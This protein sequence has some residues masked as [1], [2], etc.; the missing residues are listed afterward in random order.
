MVTLAELVYRLTLA[1]WTG[2][3]AYLALLAAPA[4]FAGLPREE[5]ARAVVLLFPPYLKAGYVATGLLFA[6]ALVLARAGRRGYRRRDPLASFRVLATGAMLALAIYGG[7][8]VYPKALVLL[9]QVPSL[10]GDEL[11]PARVEFRRVHGL[12]FGLNGLALALSAL[13]LLAQAVRDVRRQG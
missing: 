8:V 4:L 1:L 12:A 11:S 3:M 10:N 9:G 13:L 6:A 7:L 5:A 2:A